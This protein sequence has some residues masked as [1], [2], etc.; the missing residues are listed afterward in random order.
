MINENETATEQSSALEDVKSRLMTSISE[1]SNSVKESDDA[2]EPSDESTSNNESDRGT[3]DTG[4][5]NKSDKTETSESEEQTVASNGSDESK[6]N[7]VKPKDTSA[8]AR[9]RELNEK[10]KQAEARAKELEAKLA[11]KEQGTTQPPEVKAAPET[12]QPTRQEIPHLVPPPK[13][14]Q[15]EKAQLL[16]LLRKYQEE[17]NTEMAWAVQQEIE[18]IRDYELAAAKWEGQNAR[19]WENHQATTSHWKNEAAKKWPELAK[20]DS[21]ISKAR[22]RVEAFIKEVQS[23]PAK[24]EYNQAYMA[25]IFDRS[26][27]F[28]AAEA[29]NKQLREKIAKLEKKGQPVTQTEVP[30]ADSSAK[31]SKDEGLA[32]VKSRL[33]QA[34]K[35][36]NAR[37]A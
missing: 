19:A 14:P 5:E 22:G 27:R 34:V 8:N 36:H 26:T 13:K 16:P 29:E 35:S 12:Q 21:T 17:G 24:F 33:R 2:D 20:A 9:I 1:R 37:R 28:D 25:D 30:E 23:N 11:A 31:S 18:S 7:N 10:A 3:T 15:Y 4:E 32:D 6:T